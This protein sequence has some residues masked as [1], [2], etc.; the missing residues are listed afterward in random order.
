M[1]YAFKDV[2]GPKIEIS[3]TTNDLNNAILTYADNGKGIPESI[4][5]NQSSGFG[6][7][8]IGMLIQ[9]LRGKGEIIRNEKPM[10]RIKFPLN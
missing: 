4:H 2:E 5:F 7:Q 9:Q 1:K 8:L 6:M 10:I 3:L